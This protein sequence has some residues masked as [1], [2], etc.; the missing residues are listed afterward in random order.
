MF[1]LNQTNTG[2]GL[3]GSTASTTMTSGAAAAPAPF[4][5]LAGASPF[6]GEQ[7]IFLI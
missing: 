3:F 7:E 6:G 2:A 4:G 1:N 5:A